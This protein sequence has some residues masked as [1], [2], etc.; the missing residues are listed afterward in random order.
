MTATFESAK[1]LK[2]AGFPQPLP[3]G[4]QVWFL[5]GGLPLVVIA[6]ATNKFS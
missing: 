4:V 2:E 3:L 5:K 6:K 1:R